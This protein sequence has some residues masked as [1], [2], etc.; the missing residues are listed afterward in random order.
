MKKTFSLHHEKI[1]A[2]RLVDS[3]KHDVKKYVK[4]ERNKSLP[5]GAD[6]CDFDCKFGSTESEAQEIHLSAINKHIDEAVQAGLTSFYVEIIAKAGF[7]STQT[8][9]EE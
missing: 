8:E 3:I 2:P 7:R 6:F 4:R 1:K 9:E 5:E